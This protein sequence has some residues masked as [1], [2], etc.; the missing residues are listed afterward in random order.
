M[1]GPFQRAGFR[2]AS[3][4]VHCIIFY[5]YLQDISVE[6]LVAELPV[7]QPRYVAYSYCLKHS[8]GRTSYPLCFIFISPTGCKPEMQMMY[9]GSKNSLVHEG[10]FGKVREEAVGGAGVIKVGGACIVKVASAIMCN[11]PIN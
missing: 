3:K 11:S 9:A 2:I 4:G 5:G 10:G 1:N 7:H 8:D 6:D